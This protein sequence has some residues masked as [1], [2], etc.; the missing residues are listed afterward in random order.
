MT[1]STDL[2]LY[3]LKDR[4]AIIQLNQAESRNAMTPEMGEALANAIERAEKEANAIAL[5]GSEKAFSAGTNLKSSRLD[6]INACLLYTSPSPR[7][8][9]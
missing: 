3:T 6:N 5:L 2:V 4:V 7:D 1:N 8:R 9:G